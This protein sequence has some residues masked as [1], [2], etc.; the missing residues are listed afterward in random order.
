MGQEVSARTS[1]LSSMVYC[2]TI[3]P[4]SSCSG[5]SLGLKQWMNRVPSPFS[6]FRLDA[7]N[8]CAL[9]L[10]TRPLCGEGVCS[11]TVPQKLLGLSGKHHGVHHL[12][13]TLQWMSMA[14]RAGQLETP[15][16]MVGLLHLITHP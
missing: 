12:Y 8:N 6:W 5:L 3:K 2:P 13:A 15:N 4:A 11:Q 7:T 16:L 10:S 9:T 1:I 14:I